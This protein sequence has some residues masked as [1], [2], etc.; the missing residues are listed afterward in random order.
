MALLA[1]LVR[2]DLLGFVAALS[3]VRHGRRWWRG[4]LTPAVIVLSLMALNVGLGGGL[5]PD[6]AAPMAWLWHSNHALAV[7]SLAETAAT[8]WWY[9]R[10]VLLGGPWAMASAMESALAVFAVVRPWWP[11]AWRAVP[12]LLVVAAFAAGAGD[13]L[14]A[15]W[16]ALLLL[17][18]P[19][20]RR[21]GV[22]RDLAAL[23]LGGLVLLG[24]HWALRW[25]P[26]DYYIA[27]LV[28]L[29]TAALLRFGRVRLVLLV[30]ALAQLIDLPRVRAEP[31]AGQEAMALAGR[32]LAEVLPAQ[33][34][35]GCFNSGILTFTADV[36]RRS[37]ATRRAVVNLDG[38]VDA[39]A[40]AA[41][42][43]GRLADWL[44]EQDVR[45]VLDNPVQF[46][47]DPRLPHANGPWFAPDFDPARDLLELARFVVPAVGVTRPGTGGFR[48]YWRRGRGEP[49]VLPAA[50]RDLG[51]WRD[52]R[53]VWWPARA[54][55]RLVIERQDGEP[56]TL[57]AVD[58][59]T[60]V[61][62]AV[63][64]C[65]GW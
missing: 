40:F 3:L 49:P 28:V 10:P 58:C 26:R 50:A 47:T 27:P 21:R 30:F 38:V 32:H 6:S 1:S 36:L 15:G 39:R 12:A 54:G 43:R 34:R 19:A 22:P 45:Y 18:F 57:A 5:A 8:W 9:A 37:R 52:G 7:P 4:L 23:L 64:F 35:V 11:C 31:L 17:V 61:I 20:R 55:Q 62:V 53:C 60:T 16:V 33:Q 14:S 46:A 24:V 48:L 44:D 65:S 63:P 25:Y 13:L 29:A 51:S 2:T 42:R 59:D 41:L 56:L